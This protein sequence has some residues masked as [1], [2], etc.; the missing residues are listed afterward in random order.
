MSE[1]VDPPVKVGERAATDVRV[2]SGSSS[3]EL[4]VSVCLEVGHT[5]SMHLLAGH[6]LPDLFVKSCLVWGLVMSA[7]W[8]VQ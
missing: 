3:A 8:R 4:G 6:R 7:C 5:P 2:Y 1:P